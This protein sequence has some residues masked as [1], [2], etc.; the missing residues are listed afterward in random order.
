MHKA[1][2]LQETI[3]A[4]RVEPGHWYLDGTFG[5]GGHTAAILEN[6]G[7]V[8]AFD[9]DSEAIAYGQEAFATHVEAGQLILVRENF[10]KLAMVVRQNV[11]DEKISGILFDFGTS[12]DQLKDQHRGFSFDGDAELDMRMDDRLGV[13]AKDLLAV[14][15]EKQL[16][17]L[18]L[19]E[20]GEREGKAIA[21]EIVWQRQKRGIE[22]TQQL[23][24]II[25]KAKHDRRG[26]LNP[27]TK[28]FQAL[29]IA[30]NG[31]LESIQAVLPQ[32]MKVLAPKGRIACISF[33][34]GEDRVVK[35]VFK[36]WQS[37]GIGQVVT[38]EIVTAGE[39]ELQDNKRARSA[40]LRVF[41]KNAEYV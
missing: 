7:R 32:A 39:E 30:V 15:S 5:R 3:E 35:Q 29:R 4:L 6:G 31:E 10:D 9:V 18:F 14:L 33:H 12:S 37:D 34:E 16:A 21:H 27:A 41:E 36:E 1:V 25:E 24:Q 2:L 8:L 26:H 38:K 40:K 11:P 17:N 19:T 23:V 20:G 22:T 28:V 13:K